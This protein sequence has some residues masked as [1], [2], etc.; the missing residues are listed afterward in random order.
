LFVEKLLFFDIIY[1]LE[2]KKFLLPWV[3][4]ME[5]ELFNPDANLI[6]YN[7]L[8]EMK[9]SSRRSRN[10]NKEKAE[11]QFNVTAKP[12]KLETFFRE[13]I[14]VEPDLPDTTAEISGLEDVAPMILEPNIYPSNSDELSVEVLE[15]AND[16]LE[17]QNS[18]EIQLQTNS[19]DM[20]S[21]INTEMKKLKTVTLLTGV[22][23][24]HVSIRNEGPNLTAKR[25]SFKALQ[26]FSFNENYAKHFTMEKTELRNINTDMLIDES[27]ESVKWLRKLG[28][29]YQSIYQQ[30]MD[31][32]NYFQTF[33][34]DE[35]ILENLLPDSKFHR[36]LGFSTILKHV[37]LEMMSNI[38]QPIGN[39]LPGIQHCSYS[40]YSL[41]FILDYY[42]IRVFGHDKVLNFQLNYL[43][44]IP[45]YLKSTK[46]QKIFDLF[47][48]LDPK[49]NLFNK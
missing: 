13:M 24:H 19:S 14:D 35:D 28:G 11:A 48:Y 36:V 25:F 34:S 6:N 15:T 41:K 17:M 49:V 1:F 37:N 22:D 43:H 26:L 38:Y 23:E 4:T 3:A 2:P 40:M 27:I 39:F 21:N 33:L 45:Y 18:S 12:I 32:E 31:N 20:L 30:M 44:L 16:L 9:R 46:K 10:R 42:G 8:K 7:E 5:F 29:K 47:E